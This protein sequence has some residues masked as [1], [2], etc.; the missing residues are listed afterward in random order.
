MKINLIVFAASFFLLSTACR[1]KDEDPNPPAPAPVKYG[2]VNF[3]ITTYDSLGHVEPVHGGVKIFLV[4]DNISATTDAQGKVSFENLPYGTH[5]PVFTKDGYAGPM[6]TVYLQ[7]PEYTASFPVARHS[8]YLVSGYNSASYDRDNVYVSF[9]LAP[10]P[11]TDSTVQMLVLAHTAADLS[12]RRFSSADPI[13]IGSAKVT[14]YNIAQL[15]KFKAFIQQLDSAAEFYVTVAPVSY[16]LFQG[17]LQEGKQV[18]GESLKPA[19]SARLIKT[20]KN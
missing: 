2:K 13:F 3:Q 11:A 6:V 17:N 15:P 20:W 18:L 7:V 1:K 5:T 16:G 9:N 8:H 10:P 19:G 12:Q 4:E 14:D